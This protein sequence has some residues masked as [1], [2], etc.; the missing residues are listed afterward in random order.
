MDKETR[1]ERIRLLSEVDDL[2]AKC[3]TCTTRKHFNDLKDATGL[4]QSCKACPTGQQISQYGE[5]FLN[6]L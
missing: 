3:K 2:Q 1:K 4:S 5:K 6:L